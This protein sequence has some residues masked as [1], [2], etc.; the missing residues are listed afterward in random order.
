MKGNPK[1]EFRSPKED[2]GNSRKA[3]KREEHPKEAP[4]E[5]ASSYRQIR[6]PTVSLR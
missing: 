2:R 4:R 3:W 6:S 5:F 1:A